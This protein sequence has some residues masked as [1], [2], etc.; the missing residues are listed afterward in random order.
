MTTYRV[1]PEC[2]PPV[3]IFGGGK[4]PTEC[5]HGERYFTE[6]YLRSVGAG[7]D[8]IRPQAASRKHGDARG[9]G[10]GP[11]APKK[12]RRRSTGPKRDWSLAITKV[13]EEA[14][15]RIC[16]RSDCKLDA[17]HVLGREHDE[18]KVD[19]DGRP[20]KELLVHPDRV[21]PAC[22]PFPN[23]CHGDV[24]MKRVNY[25]PYLTLPEQ[26]KAVEDCG[27]IAPAYM[28]LMPVEH[29]EERERSAA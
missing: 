1:K 21:F 2:C 4:K 24:D 13:E 23:G 26:L 28:R 17:A 5:Q 29:R 15:C 27:G 18:P 16:K 9:V 11:S 20:L 12:Q 6:T 8:P 22:G 19:G 10:V 25:L 14:C 7:A 3:T